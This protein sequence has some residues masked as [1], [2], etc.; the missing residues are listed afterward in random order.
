M[1]KQKLIPSWN[2]YINF[3]LFLSVTQFSF[4]YPIDH[5]YAT[6]TTGT[7]INKQVI[8]KVKLL[9]SS[10][11]IIWELI[12]NYNISH[13]VYT[14][15]TLITTTIS[16]VNRKCCAW[17]LKRWKDLLRHR[18]H[19]SALISNDEVIEALLLGGS[20]TCCL[21]KLHNRGRRWNLI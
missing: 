14:M 4:L 7:G 16:L 1:F 20:C 3:Y 2:H 17:S 18:Q 21:S 9:R 8:F 6:H 11:I 12:G 10:Y 13:L 15:F 19:L 5:A